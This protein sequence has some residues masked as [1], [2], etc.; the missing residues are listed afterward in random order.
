M[1]DF[2][3]PGYGLGHHRSPVPWRRI[4]ACPHNEIEPPSLIEKPRTF[5]LIFILLDHNITA[6]QGGLLQ[7]V[8]APHVGQ[9]HRLDCRIRH[10]GKTFFTR[11]NFGTHSPFQCLA[12]N[13]F[14]N[15]ARELSIFTSHSSHLAPSNSTLEKTIMEGGLKWKTQI[16]PGN[17]RG[18]SLRHIIY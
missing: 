18:T 4:L 5:R 2:C 11:A 17:I 10:W 3:H 6:L 1:D 7:H 9:L 16:L 15:H 13:R 12:P 14:A 8:R